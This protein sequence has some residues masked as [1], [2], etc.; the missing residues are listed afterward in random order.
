MA[1]EWSA[2]TQGSTPRG[3]KWGSRALLAS[4]VVLAGVVGLF[5]GSLRNPPK[6]TLVLGTPNAVT[7]ARFGPTAGFPPPPPD[8]VVTE[9]NSST[10][11][12]LVIDANSLPLFPSGTINVRS[13][14]VPTTR[15]GFRTRMAIVEVFTSSDEDARVSALRSVPIIPLRGRPPTRA[16]STASTRSFVS[17]QSFLCDC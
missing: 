1:L 10:V 16:C 4:A 14:T 12:R 13:T 9:T 7:V 2:G 11:S 15:C 3:S 5:F 6:A 8:R 17:A